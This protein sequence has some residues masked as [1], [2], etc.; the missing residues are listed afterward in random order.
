M[1]PNSPRLV[2]DLDNTLTIDGPEDY[3]TKRPNVSA[4]DTLRKYRND[5]FTIAIHTSR[6]M[7]TYE[8]SVGAIT[9]N[10]VPI[11][12]DWLKKHDVP[13]DEIWVGKPWCGDNG[14]Y[15]DDRAIRPSEFCNLSRQEIEDLLKREMQRDD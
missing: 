6:N 4:I 2:I 12:I 9:A 13:Y 3:S 11:V 15:V 1:K 10:T 5:G 7:R 8:S 14:F